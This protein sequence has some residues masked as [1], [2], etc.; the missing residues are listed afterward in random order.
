[1]Y[2]QL[3]AEGKTA[4]E[5]LQIL[6][7]CSQLNY[8][9]TKQR[10]KCNGSPENSLSVNSS[11]VDDV[12]S[13]YYYDDGIEKKINS[14]N[15]NF[16]HRVKLMTKVI[17]DR[18]EESSSS[19]EYQNLLK[20][21]HKGAYL[22]NPREGDSAQ[23]YFAS[24]REYL[25]V[26][27]GQHDKT[28]S[29]YKRQKIEDDAEE[30]DALDPAS[31]YS[32]YSKQYYPPSSPIETQPHRKLIKRKRRHIDIEREARRIRAKYYSSKSDPEDP[33]P[34]V[35]LKVSVNEDYPEGDPDDVIGDC[36]TKKTFE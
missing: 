5:A 6:S 20:Q 1:M 29:G 36:F 17:V 31:F 14:M 30:F 28:S 12:E 22:N 34:T 10:A 23:S 25:K 11:D 35:R 24:K 19:D 27:R 15:K 16:E 26:Y 2:E 18:I 13:E 32:N 9:V 8:L 7:I 3:K 4:E 33:Y 21:N